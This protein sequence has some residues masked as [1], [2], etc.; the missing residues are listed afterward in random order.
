MAFFCVCDNHLHPF[1]VECLVSGLAMIHQTTDMDK[2]WQ[3]SAKVTAWSINQNQN[4]FFFNEIDINIIVRNKLKINISW[5]NNRKAII[6]YVFPFISTAWFP[7]N[8]CKWNLKSTRKKIQNYTRW[9]C[10][11][12]SVSWWHVHDNNPPPV[13]FISL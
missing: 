5:K 1:T 13:S 4:F 9:Y 10:L 12:T 2:P 11:C 6:L 7:T 3:F 8:V